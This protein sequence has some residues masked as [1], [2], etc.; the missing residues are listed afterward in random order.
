MQRD[1]KIGL[2]VGVTLAAVAIIWLA[3]LPNLSTRARALRAAS[4]INPSPKMPADI[5][6]TPSNESR[7]TSDNQQATP[8]PSKRGEPNGPASSI[9]NRVSSDDIP[10]RIHIVQK[11]DTLS[12]ISS[13][14]YGSAKQWRKIVAANHDTL[15]DPNRLTPG[16]KLII[17]D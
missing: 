16:I 15:P 17:P 6:P 11:G 5:S 8:A 3:T 2:A 14:Y 9:E 10:Q 12:S 13:K 4:N 7:A 1:F